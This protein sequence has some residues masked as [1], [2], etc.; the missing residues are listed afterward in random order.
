MRTNVLLFAALI[1]VAPSLALG[2]PAPGPEEPRKE[3]PAVKPTPTPAT[4]KKAPSREAAPPRTQEKKTDPRGLQV[5][6]VDFKKAPEKPK[7][8]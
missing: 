1:V 4:A 6:P 8:S 2:A 5:E 3:A 7:P